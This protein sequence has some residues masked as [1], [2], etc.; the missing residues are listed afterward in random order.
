MECWEIQHVS[1]FY[2]RVIQCYWLLVSF[3]I[4]QKRFPF[5]SLVCFLALWVCAI[6]AR[7][8]EAKERNQGGGVNC[9]YLDWASADDN[10]PHHFRTLQ[11]KTKGL[12]R[13]LANESIGSRSDFDAYNE[14]CEEQFA[15]FSYK[16]KKRVECLGNVIR[17]LEAFKGPLQFLRDE[18]SGKIHKPLKKTVHALE[19]FVNRIKEQCKKASAENN[20]K[21]DPCHGLESVTSEDTCTE[22][23]QTAGLTADSKKEASVVLAHELKKL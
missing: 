14:L 22:R 5:F 19:T 18:T 13:A 9:S 4:Y 16:C 7:G 23:L 17:R 1:F 3:G 20:L 12:L 21:E 10:L 8:A 6:F 11:K 15:K 2:L